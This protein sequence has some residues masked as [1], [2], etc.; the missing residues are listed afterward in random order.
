MLLIFCGVFIDMAHS[1]FPDIIGIITLE[2]G[3]EMI[4]MSLIC[5]YSYNVFKFGIEFVPSILN[6][7]LIKILNTI[8]YYFY[9]FIVF[10]HLMQMENNEKPAKAMFSIK[11]Y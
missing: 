1:K 8:A 7:S 11:S 10:M 4:A 5:W 9:N 3:G 2:D 6:K